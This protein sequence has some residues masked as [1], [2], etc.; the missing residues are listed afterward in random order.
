MLVKR[1]NILFDKDLWEKLSALAKKQKT[2]IGELTRKAVQKA[3]FAAEDTVQ[4]ER[5]EAVEGILRFREQYG[6][7]LAKGEDSTTLI[8]NMR[9]N[10]YGNENR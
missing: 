3:Y 10:R 1:T 9:E 7:K 5:E 8:R 6:K 2:S 4:K